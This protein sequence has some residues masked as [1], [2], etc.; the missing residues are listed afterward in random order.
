MSEWASD[1]ACLGVRAR[2]SSRKWVF[3]VARLLLHCLIFHMTVDL[4]K[5]ILKMSDVGLFIVSLSVSGRLLDI[6]KPPLGNCA[7]TYW[8]NLAAIRRKREVIDRIAVTFEL[9][10]IGLQT[11]KTR[12]ISPT[13]TCNTFRIYSHM[14]AVWDIGYSSYVEPI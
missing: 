14:E 5:Q 9:H 6:Q 4:L 7:A 12:L 11:Y 3:E 1:Y 10:V 2:V 8:Q 13:T